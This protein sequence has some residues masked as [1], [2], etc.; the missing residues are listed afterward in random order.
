MSGGF[1]ARYSLFKASDHGPVLL[2]LALLLGM[3]ER[4]SLLEFAAFRRSPP[5]L[6]LR[7]L[8]DLAAQGALPSLDFIDLASELLRLRGMLTHARAQHGILREQSL[9]LGVTGYLT[10][11]EDSKLLPERLCFQHP[12]SGCFL[13][14]CCSLDG[15]A[16]SGAG[17]RNRATAATAAGIRRG[18]GCSGSGMQHHRGDGLAAVLVF[19]GRLRALKAHRRRRHKCRGNGFTP[20]RC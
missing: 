1:A 2:S 7:S 17:Y 5:P 8:L 14:R 19:R 16:G 9:Y 18:R 3:G 10:T 4:E 20:P 6:F 12:A 15:I 11:S 13:R